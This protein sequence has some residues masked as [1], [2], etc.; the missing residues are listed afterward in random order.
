[1][2]DGVVVLLA[3]V[4][5]SA[6][7]LMCESVAVAEAVF[8]DMAACK[9]AAAVVA[10]RPPRAAAHDDVTMARCRY[11]DVQPEDGTRRPAVAFAGGQAVADSRGP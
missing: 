4:S 7:L 5:C 9:A 10:P 6:D 3:V 1:M 8:A 2:I 11:A